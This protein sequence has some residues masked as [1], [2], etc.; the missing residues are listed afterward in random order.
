MK[1][2]G[3]AIILVST[4]FAD[5]KTM[6][7]QLNKFATSDQPM[8]RSR[9]SLDDKGQFSLWLEDVDEYGCWCYFGDKHGAGKSQP[10]NELDAHCKQLHEGYECAII[11]DAG[12]NC[13]PWTVTYTAVN[14][15]L[16]DASVLSQCEA[17]NG[18]GTCAAHACSVE[19][20]FLRDVSFW[21]IFNFL[22]LPSYSHNQG[23]F[24]TTQSCHVTMGAP[25]TRAC[26]G[27][28]GVFLKT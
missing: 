22:D 2:F 26:C 25:S 14:Y 5:L 27:T 9:R 3:A 7:D 4:C 18:A 21:S 23:S 24:N 13:E 17:V 15:L 6:Q 8:V 11:D 16:D 19:S 12:N 20:R 1:L 28:Y 10:V